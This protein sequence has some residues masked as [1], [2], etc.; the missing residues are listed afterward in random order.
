MS[1]PDL[2]TYL[3]KVISW[4][5][6]LHMHP[7]L[8][9]QEVRTSNLI[10]DLLTKFGL[11]V[12]RNFAGTA[13]L[14]TLHTNKPGKT[15]VLRAD[16]DALPIQDAKD[17]PYRSQI[18]GV[19]H[20]CGHDAH[21]ANLLGVANYISDHRTEFCGTIKFLFQP[22]EE[23]LEGAKLVCQSGV[24]DGTDYILGQHA[25][26]DVDVGQVQVCYGPSNG[27]GDEFTLRLHGVGCHGARPHTGKDPILLAAKV[28]EGFQ[29][30]ISRELDPL[31]AAVISVCSVQAGQHVVMKKL[32]KLMCLLL[33]V[34]M[35]MGIASCSSD[36]GEGG[37]GSS[38]GTETVRISCGPLT[39]YQNVLYISIADMMNKA[40]P[41]KYSFAIEASTGSAENARLLAMDETDFGTMG[42]D[43]TL[44]CYNA[45]G[46]FE[47][48]PAEQIMHV[49]T[50]SGTG[51]TVHVITSAKSDINSIPDLAGTKFG[52]TAGMMAGYLDDVLWAY[53]MTTDDLGSVVN[54][55]LSDLCTALQ[56]GNIDA[57]LYATPAPGTNFTDL[58][59]S[60][61]I[62]VV[63]IGQEAVDKLM[64]EKPW[65]HTVVIPAGTYDGCDEDI[66]TFAQYTALCAR[67]DVPEET[68]YNLVKTM[69][70]NADALEA[71]HKNAAGTCPERGIEGALI[72]MHPG[73]ERYYKEVGVLD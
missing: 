73:A 19:C 47:G 31:K 8:G 69:M 27:G 46:E 9:L 26:L 29:Q 40:N 39:G 61:G 18:S 51:A 35:L 5:R 63:D 24:L 13:V 20:A 3:P 62:K 53:D 33:A 21:T 34:G 57:F 12:Q 25:V 54:L 56:D 32:S 6:D 41:G 10:A 7:E 59:M 30:I 65:Y 36:A 14:G 68:V 60:F 58:A 70:E 64:A 44:S 72:P 55:S 28:I 37:G 2:E 17:V 1:I 48:L 23:L 11:D 42:M 50:H 67:A 15:V 38:G 45:E 49:A 43:M 66:T 71:V 16:M 22:A 4:R 52:V